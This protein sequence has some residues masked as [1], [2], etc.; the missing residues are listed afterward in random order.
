MTKKSG[1]GPEGSGILEALAGALGQFPEL[2]TKNG[3][4]RGDQETLK[5]P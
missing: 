5:P 4:S 3:Q 1:I 2:S